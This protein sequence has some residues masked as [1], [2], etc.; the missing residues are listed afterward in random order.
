[1]S[2][3]AARNFL[4]RTCTEMII[5]EKARATGRISKE[6]V[7]NEEK[8]ATIVSMMTAAVM[9]LYSLSDMCDR[10]ENKVRFKCFGVF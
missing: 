5:M 4:E 1:V 7:I 3:E 9:C 10:R 2:R 6:P 8:L